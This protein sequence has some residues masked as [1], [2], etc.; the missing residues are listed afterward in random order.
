MHFGNLSLAGSNPIKGSSFGPV[1]GPVYVEFSGSQC[2]DPQRRYSLL[3]CDYRPLGLT[4]PACSDHANDVAVVCPS[5]CTNM[6]IA[7]YILFSEISWM[8]AERLTRF[9]Y[10]SM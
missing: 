8:Y 3:D 7:A 5:K 1:S 4:T 6:F 2:A 10:C 9:L